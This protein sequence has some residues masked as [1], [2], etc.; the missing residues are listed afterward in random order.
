MNQIPLSE[1]LER[2]RKLPEKRPN[3]LSVKSAGLG[4]WIIDRSNS[5]LRNVL[6]GVNFASRFDIITKVASRTVVHYEIY[7]FLCFLG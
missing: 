4:V 5:R 7:M 2:V 1:E 6:K 3:N